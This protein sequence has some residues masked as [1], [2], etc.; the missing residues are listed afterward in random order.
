MRSSGRP[1]KTTQ[2]PSNP[3]RIATG[4]ATSA[5]ASRVRTVE[6]GAA[7][8]ATV[9]RM[10]ALSS[11]GGTAGA[12]SGSRGE[13]ASDT[14]HLLPARPREGYAQ[15]L[16]SAGSPLLHGVPRGSEDSRRLD[17]GEPLYL[18]EDVGT[19]ILL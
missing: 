6:R 19:P 13:R 5:S 16:V 9:A 3:T 14:E 7:V 17:G 4:M 15:R 12:T 8:W 2:L 11:K 10:R 1:R 18:E